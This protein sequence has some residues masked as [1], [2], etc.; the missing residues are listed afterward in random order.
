MTPL[1]IITDSQDLWPSWL[2]ELHKKLWGRHDLFGQIFHTANLTKRDF[3]DL[4]NELQDLHPSRSSGSYTAEEAL[5]TKSNFLR[6][7]GVID[8]DPAHYVG[9]DALVPQPVFDT[10]KDL[11]PLIA[12][13]VD[14]VDTD[15]SDV[16]PMDTDATDVDEDPEPSNIVDEANY[17]SERPTAIFPRTVR[18]VDLTTLGLS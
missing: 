6:S 9:S 5:V 8:T 14:A 13:D 11:T 2:V 1:A 7:R 4:Q 16:S 18:Y 10:S 12:A 3:I 15:A 17:L